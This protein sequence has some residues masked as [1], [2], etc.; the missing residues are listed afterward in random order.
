MS[1]AIPNLANE[2]NQSVA[3]ERIEF[4][5]EIPIGTPNILKQNYES[6]DYDECEN[7][8]LV[9]EAQRKGYPWEIRKKIYRWFI[10]LIV[11]LL[12]AFIGVVIDISIH[13]LADIKYRKLKEYLDA[14]SEL[15]CVYNPYI[16]WLLSN[17]V[18]VLPGAILV[19]Y[20]EPIAMGSGIPHVKCY[21]NGI[22]MPHIVRLRTLVVKV[23]GVISAVVGGLAC[24]KEGPMIHSGAVI[25]AG[26][27][28]GKSYLLKFVNIQSFSKFRDDREK[29]DFVSGGAAA[30]VAAA[31]GAPVGGVLFA[32][33]EGASFWNQGLTWRIFFA[34]SVS[35]FT[36]N[37]CMSWYEDH[38]GNMSYDGLLNFG[39]FDDLNYHMPELIIFVIMGAIGGLLGAFYNWANH[40]LTVF[41]MRYVRTKWLKV[42]EVLMVSAVSCTLAISMVYGIE[43]C[44]RIDSQDN[45]SSSA[46]QMHCKDG[47]YNSQASLWIQ[48]PEDTVQSFFHDSNGTHAIGSLLPFVVV[49]YILSIWTYGISVSSGLFIPCLLVGAA[50]G[51]I[52]GIALQANFPDAPILANPGKYALIGAAAQLGGVVRMTISLTVILI[53]ATGS[54]IFGLP[55]MITLLT[56]KWV[57]DFFNEGIYDMHIQLSGVPLLAWDPPPL[58]FILD[59]KEFMS[60]KKM[61]TLNPVESVRKI[62][63]IL[64]T[65]SHNGF[66]VVDPTPSSGDQ[67]THGRLKGLILRSQLIVMLQ[68]KIF[69]VNTD[70]WDNSKI[71]MNMFRNLYPRYPAIE[72]IAL[73]EEEMRRTMDLT[74]FMNPSPYCVQM[75]SSMQRVFRLFRALG[76]RHVIVINETNEVVG[77]VTR[78]DLA[79]YRVWKNFGQC[80]VKELKIV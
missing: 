29:R 48:L 4:G 59:A 58:S 5:E 50:W 43:Q 37:A 49:Y 74:P 17:L 79:K 19:A 22:K 57:G 14:C 73:T 72:D 20:V 52:I 16:F 1:V 25:A 66:P 70:G 40:K 30:G 62:V 54:I 28:Q 38:P 80:G 63:R 60:K 51:R 34:S 53:E 44:A 6:L 71:N 7:Q 47:E 12:T 64:R 21:L 35:A 26:I 9:F 67:V 39:S 75:I 55:L 24:G 18:T 8:L 36:L 31:F 13:L 15:N 45:P 11:G 2:R 65:T 33:E 27:S 78:K 42:L 77:I 10:C 69:N 68:N 56:A 46:I 3:L 23:V 76:L 61:V 32:L 41:R